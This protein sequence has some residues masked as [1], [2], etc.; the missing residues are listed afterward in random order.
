MDGILG[1]KKKKPDLGK[2]QQSVLK[3]PSSANR[4]FT[5]ADE[6]GEN[7]AGQTRDCQKASRFE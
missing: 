7:R 5:T 3:R 4:K 6:E 2:L 1:Q